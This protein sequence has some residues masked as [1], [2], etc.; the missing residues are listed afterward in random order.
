MSALKRICLLTDDRHDRSPPQKKLIPFPGCDFYFEQSTITNFHIA[1]RFKKLTAYAATVVKTQNG[2]AE[3][4]V[5]APPIVTVNP[6]AQFRYA[7][8]VYSVKKVVDGKVISKLTY[9]DSDDSDIE[10]LELGNDKLSW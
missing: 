2:G 9:E 4:R 3:G 8:A 7:G 1:L 10:E 5:T 6:H